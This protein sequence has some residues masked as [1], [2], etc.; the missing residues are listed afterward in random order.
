[1]STFYLDY[2]VTGDER[3]RL[4]KAIS[5]FTQADAKYFGAPTFAYEVDYFH[6]DRR[7]VVSFDDR[8][9]SEEIEGLIDALVGQGFVAQVSDRGIPTAKVE[10]PEHATEEPTSPTTEPAAEAP[11]DAEGNAD[12]TGLTINLPLDGFN[13]DSLDRLQKLIEKWKE[14]SL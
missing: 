9:E 12:A 2:N 5:A 6:I 7:G 3:K 1:M 13:P 11:V 14:A 4:V 10:E 8:A